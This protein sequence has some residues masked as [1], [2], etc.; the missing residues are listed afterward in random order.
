[1]QGDL[2]FDIHEL[3]LRQEAWRANGSLPRRGTRD[4]APGSPMTSAR[5]R[6][7]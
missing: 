3:R 2:G 6:E 4:S 7:R 1:M 5:C